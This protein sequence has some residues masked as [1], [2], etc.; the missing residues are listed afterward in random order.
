[1][2][3]TTHP[4]LQLN[5]DIVFQV[6]AQRPAI[7]VSPMSDVKSVVYCMS[8]HLALCVSVLPTPQTLAYEYS[9]RYRGELI[10]LYQRNWAPRQQYL[11]RV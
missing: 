8:N 10:I 9:F 3:R 5:F 11:D 7:V 1:M 4:L 6:R 2:I